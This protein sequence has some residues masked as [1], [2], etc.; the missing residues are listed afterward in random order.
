MELNVGVPVTPAKRPYQ[1]DTEQEGAMDACLPIGPPARLSPIKTAL[2]PSPSESLAEET[3]PDEDIAWIHDEE[4]RPIGQVIPNCPWP[5]PTPTK[6]SVE[7]P[8][9]TLI[10]PE[11][12]YDG[13]EIPAPRKSEGLAIDSLQRRLEESASMSGQPESEDDE[14]QEFI[15][16]DFS[17]YTDSA[18]SGFEM[19]PLQYL[20][21]KVTGHSQYY[22]DGVLRVKDE[23]YFVQKIPF[24]E[25]SV[26]NYGAE[27]DS[28]DGHIWIRSSQNEYLGRE[29][30]YKLSQPSKC[31]AR[32]FAKFIWISN[33]AKYFVD[34]LDMSAEKNKSVSIHDFRGTFL[35]TTAALHQKSAAFKGWFG[36]YGKSDFRVPV[37]ANADFLYKEACGVLSVEAVRFHRV[38]REIL[39]FD[40]YKPVLPDDPKSASESKPEVPPTIVTPYTAYCFGHLPCGS[41][42]QPLE[43]DP[44]VEALR[45]RVADPV[46]LELT[47]R[48][49]SG[50]EFKAI[51][52][53]TPDVTL[54][55]EF[56]QAIKP[57]DTISIPPDPDSLS[58]WRQEMAHGHTYGDDRWY[59]LVQEVEVQKGRRWFNIIWYY[60]PA[61]TICGVMKYPVPN[62]LF[63]SNHCTCSD[64]IR[65]DEEE[66][67]G[68]HS[69][70]FWPVLE[71][72][73]FI[74]RQ[75]YDMAERRYTAYSE[76][77]RICICNRKYKSK[78]AVD[79]FASK[80]HAGDAV[81]VP[82]KG[83]LEPF[84]LLDIDVLLRQVS[85][86]RLLRRD[87][88]EGESYRPN[89]IVYTDDVIVR[90]FNCIRRKC[91]VYVE[92]GT[93][94][95]PAPYDRDG[96]GTLFFMTHFWNGEECVPL[97]QRQSPPT[98]NP[99]PSG[100]KLL[101]LDLFCGVGNLGRGLEE[102]GGVDMLWANDI[103]D[104]AIHAYMANTEDPSQVTPFLGSIDVLQQ[105][106]IQG[107]FGDGVPK[108]GLVGVIAGG[109]PCPGFSRLTN[110]KTTPQ[111]RKN[112]SLIAAF[113]SMVDLYRPRYGILENVLGIV[114]REGLKKED[115]F[116]QLICALVGMGYQVQ[117]LF[118]DA[119]SYGS[120]QSRC[121]V[122]LVF[123]APGEELPS[124]PPP[125]HSHPPG[126]KNLG[127][128]ILANGEKMAMREF[129]DAYPFKYRSAGEATADLP[130]VYDAK[131]DYCIPFP[132]HIPSQT[133]TRTLR[134]QIKAIPH[135]P[136]GMS[137]SHAFYGGVMAPGDRELFPAE[138]AR[139][140][141]GAMGWARQRKDRL[142]STVVA[143]QSIT[144][145]KAGPQVHWSGERPLTLM[146]ARRAQGVPDCE[147]LVGG[148]RDKWR[149]VGNGVSREVAVALGVVFRDAI[150]RRH[151]RHGSGGG[152]NG[153]VTAKR[154]D[155][156][157][158]AG[159][160]PSPRSMV[161][162]AESDAKSEATLTDGP[163]AR[164]SE[165]IEQGREGSGQVDLIVVPDR[166]WETTPRDDEGSEAEVFSTE[167]PFS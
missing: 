54:S 55:R 35:D 99:P 62:E 97:G 13:Y 67:L 144:D 156:R 59:G 16:E 167:R 120:C 86:R 148:L 91:D 136:P 12:L 111:Q 51:P 123:A 100:K 139:V 19:K 124:V 3:D 88:L 134:A 165:T 109:S 22:F 146:E 68:V 153:V 110:D 65:I 60:R 69:V 147:V 66:V 39:T 63:L 113:A 102:G 26:G 108:V 140:M 11:S 7:V 25:L 154:W 56:I 42:I 128:G 50:R 70:S 73:E 166:V 77:D 133:M 107:R 46:S 38:F 126:T 138:G 78:R 10:F 94:K 85:L 95:I 31:Y 129:H 163:P 21:A 101:G 80:Y 157:L 47:K 115:V 106:A 20:N 9:T 105:R 76:S 23:R 4:G 37:S 34:Y 137:F 71:D 84:E 24:K 15:L 150:F 90:S 29:L 6:L 58:K 125:S 132:D 119:W 141:P 64:N 161:A 104:K 143:S 82:Q 75:T 89:E 93:R 61:D 121:R 57:G 49:S 17:M 164:G 79:E 160:Y 5:L 114:Q 45:E 2:L 118:L 92:T 98:L 36:A 162:G 33:L 14:F 158:K 112:Q 117:M 131:T 130:D 83:Q 116:C 152:E 18:H 44:E 41:V 159:P 81:L 145:C 52:R 151:G 43:L 8:E 96:T 87:A 27:N 122:F 103:S 53:T 155:E 72:S 135:Y 48:A 30:Y 40:E 142:F 1:D 32:Y 74:C 28:V 149:A 127:L